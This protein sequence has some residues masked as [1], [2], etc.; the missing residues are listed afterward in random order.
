MPRRENFLVPITELNNI[1]V[2]R[3]TKIELTLV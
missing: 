2:T 1:E 3:F